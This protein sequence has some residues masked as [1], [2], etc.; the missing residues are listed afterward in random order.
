MKIFDF[1]IFKKKKEEPKTKTILSDEEKFN[2]EKFN[3]WFCNEYD[4]YDGRIGNKGIFLR[5]D[6][7]SGHMISDWLEYL[8]VEYDESDIRKMTD[9]IRE[10]WREKLSR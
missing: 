3:D 1:N 5:L 8:Y 2:V 7:L 9:L 6:K 10:N 4:G